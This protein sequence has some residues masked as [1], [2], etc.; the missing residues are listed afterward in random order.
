MIKL[1]LKNFKHESS[2]KDS[3]T[4]KHI[5][6]GH[7]I[8]LMHSAL[9]PV[10][11]KQLAALAQM[12][13]DS[14][15]PEQQDQMKHKMSQGGSVGKPEHSPDAPI[16]KPHH[17]EYVN[18]E[19][20]RRPVPAESQQQRIDRHKIGIHNSKLK[21]AGGGN[22]G[23]VDRTKNITSD[24]VESTKQSDWESDLKSKADA[25]FGKA[26][27]PTPTPKPTNTPNYA[28][29]GN[30][31]TKSNDG[32]LG[33]NSGNQ[34][35]ADIK[36]P[37]TWWAN[38]GDVPANSIQ[39]LVTQ[40]PIP[41][42]NTDVPMPKDDIEAETKILPSELPPIDPEL[43]QRRKI[44]DQVVSDNPRTHTAQHGGGGK[45]FGPNGEPPPSVSPQD[46]AKV[47][48]IYQMQQADN[49]AQVTAAQQKAVQDNAA[50]VSMG[51]APLPIPG[52]PQGAQV[53]GTAQNP[54]Q[55]SADVLPS[56]DSTQ[57]GVA[58]QDPESMMRQGYSNQIAG[59][60]G[61]A[62]AQGQ[63]GQQQADIQQQGADA[64][65]TARSQ[66]QS[67]YNS[68]NHEREGLMH[69]V[70]NGYVNPDKFWTGDPET[71]AGGHSK[72]AAGIGMILAGFNPTSNPNAAINFLKFQMDKN[73]EAQTRNLG[74]KENLLAHNLR[75]FG[76]LRDATDMTRLMQN[77]VV[78]HQLQQ[79]AATAQ[80]P[81]AKAAAQSA[82]GQIQQQS[83]P[84]FMQF[85]MRKAMMNLGNGSAGNDPTDTS[86]A[87]HMLNY[88]YQVNPEMAKEFA[89]R[90]IPKV[91]VASVPVP[92]DV[93]A[94]LIGKKNFDQMAQHY[95]QWVK[96]NQ[97]SLNPAKI[98]QGA[99][100][101]AELQGAYRNA[102]HGGVY[103]E[104]EQDFIN[105]L[106][107]SDPAQF[108]ASIRTLP[109]VEELVRS[110]NSQLSNLKSGYGLPQMQPKAPADP[111]QQAMQWAKS[112]PNDPRA[113]K[114]LKQ[115]G[116]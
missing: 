29:G 56:Q 79:A 81:L 16:D 66:Y 38:G 87:E 106:I 80:G 44:Y 51:M 1:D 46:V 45:M 6:D 98:T 84:L 26:P 57:A 99:A 22:T 64:E 103:K 65:N 111:R 88:M 74:A 12:S 90:V 92:P 115:L 86:A 50:R 23:G 105:K 71:G 5:K 18:G 112:N 13:K 32:P 41:K 4:L 60:Q 94:E 108:V 61:S 53:P 100:M 9:S 36:D 85:A 34:T 20:Y 55:P 73:M 110:N 83:A 15:T 102:T 11:Q 7:T 104:G 116:Q 35:G 76:N 17:L 67:T 47:D 37:K 68:L 42:G 30:V 24:A 19:L 31:K 93:K 10:N 2:G 78:T 114:I 95:L 27:S 101:A 25:F 97:G 8:T 109:K 77:D 40:D 70:Q 96:Q 62:K 33:T 72:I 14:E 54:A 3:T 89:S 91:G 43:E 21:F 48:Q 63:L 49:A 113:A 39:D 82:I 28:D 58:P 107:P 69:D 52:I 75:Q 59:A